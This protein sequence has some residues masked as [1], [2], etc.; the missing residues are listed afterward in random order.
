MSS[1]ETEH[2]IKP[3]Q[4]QASQT[5]RPDMSTFFST[6]EL[7]DTSNDRQTHFNQHALPL[8]ENVAAVYRNLAN[9]FEMMRDPS[10][11]SGAP[12]QSAQDGHN[13]LLAQLVQQLMSY[14]DDPPSEVKGVP[15][16]FIEDL[17][18][19]PK[20]KLKKGEDCPICGNAFLDDP[21]PL[22][23]VLPCHKDHKYDMECIRPWLKVNNTCPLDR[24]E[25]W[26]KKEPPPPV[27][28][29]EEEYDDYYA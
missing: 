7:V 13:E 14:A 23:V 25:V 26:K 3:E 15:D 11:R 27:E 4:T 12:A 21:Y 8:P 29:D 18:R 5:R 20:S 17:D 1:Y 2:G 19:I 28:D 6:L 16:T 24:K 10:G 9:A 22:V